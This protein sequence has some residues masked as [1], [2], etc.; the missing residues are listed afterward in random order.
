[1]ITMPKRLTKSCSQAPLVY[2]VMIQ[3]AENDRN[4]PMQK[5]GSE[6][7]PQSTAGC[8]HFVY[9]GFQ[10]RVTMEVKPSGDDPVDLRCYLDLYGEVLTETWNY[11][12]TPLPV[13]DRK[14]ALG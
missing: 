9:S 8:N 2:C 3:C 10:W 13:K 14:A 7:R 6:W 1:M 12:W 4:T 5:S 11:Q